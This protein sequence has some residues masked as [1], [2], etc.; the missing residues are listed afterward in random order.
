MNEIPQRY[1]VIQIR[2]GD[3]PWQD[4]GTPFVE[5]YQAVMAGRKWYGGTPTNWRVE[6]RTDTQCNNQ[7]HCFDYS[8]W[9]PGG[10]Y[11]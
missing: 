2:E 9:C 7:E 3:G 8:E 4:V 5:A 6:M 11:T 10:L 1:S